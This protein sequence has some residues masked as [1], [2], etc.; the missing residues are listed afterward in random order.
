[1]NPLIERSIQ[2]Y[3]LTSGP[4]RCLAAGDP[5]RHAEAAAPRKEAD[6]KPALRQEKL[7]TRRPW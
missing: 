5:C 1:M 4:L 3:R 6:Q 2:L 7:N